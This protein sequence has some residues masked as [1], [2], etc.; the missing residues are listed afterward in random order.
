MNSFSRAVL[1][2]LGGWWMGWMGAALSPAA[3]PAAKPE[4]PAKQI[5]SLGSLHIIYNGHGHLPVHHL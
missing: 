1:V 3:E 4:P 2:C 5:A